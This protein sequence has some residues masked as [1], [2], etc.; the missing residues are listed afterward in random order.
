MRRLPAIAGWGAEL[1]QQQWR[2]PFEPGLLSITAGYLITGIILLA[3]YGLLWLIARDWMV[4]DVMALW[5]PDAHVGEA[6]RR[7]WFVFAWGVGFTALLQVLIARAGYI[8]LHRPSDILRKGTWISLNAGFFEEIFYRWLVFLTAM[9]V[10]RALNAITFG[11]VEW[12]YTTLLLPIANFITF[13]ALAPQLIDHPEWVLG[14]AV[15]SSNATFRRAH[16]QSGPISV[17]NSWFLGMAFFWVMFNYGLLSS[18]IIHIAYDLVVIATLSAM[19]K[20]HMRRYLY[21]S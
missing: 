21:H 13:D 18:I 15:I 5:Q 16:Q 4:V 14:A 11:V 3:V 9:V 17:V 8:S 6:M 19:S 10:I 12:A 20:A 7:V 2:D 1:F